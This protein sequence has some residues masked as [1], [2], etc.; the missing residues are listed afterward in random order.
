[1]MLPYFAI[2]RRASA[3]LIIMMPVCHM[4][5]PRW[6]ERAMPHYAAAVSCHAHFLRQHYHPCHA[7]AAITSLAVLPSRQHALLLLTARRSLRHKYH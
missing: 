1:M 5:P 6:R 2:Q 7:I 4:L 3:V